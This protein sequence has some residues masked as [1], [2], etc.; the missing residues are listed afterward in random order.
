MMMGCSLRDCVSIAND[1]FRLICSRGGRGGRG[2]RG[3][4]RPMMRDPSGK[5]RE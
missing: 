1:D 2:G 3:E 4:R 5:E